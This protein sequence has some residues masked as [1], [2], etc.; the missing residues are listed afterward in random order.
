VTSGA[1]GFD[2]KHRSRALTEGPSRAA[3]RAQ[4]KGIGYDDEALSKPIIGVASTWIETMPC[5]F[6]LRALAAKVKEGI[7]DAGGTPM[8]L[9][10]IAI[11]DGITMGTTGMK[12]SLVS[13]EI[14]ADSIELVARGH[15]F[16]AVIALSGCDKTIPGTVMAL[17]RL[18]V[19]SVML[20]GGSI[21]PGRFKGR[22]VTIQ[23]VFEA[24][25]AHAAGK[26]TDEELHELEG[27]ASPGA[28]ACGG[29]FTAN[30]MA[31]AFEVLGISPMGPSMVPAQYPSKAEVAY[32]AGKL[33][34]DV[35][36]RG[37]KPRDI[38]TR[39]ALEN[40]IAAVT[41]SG[42]STNGVLH[43]LAVAREA[44]VELSIDDFDAISDR[45]PLLCD[46][47]PGGQYVAVDL[48]EA[49]GVPVLVNRLRELGVLHADA[50]TVTGK[51]VGEIADEAEEAPG[52]RVVRGL[53]EPL[54][55]T[56]GLAIL[57]GNLAPEGCVVKLAGHERRL[58]TGPARV[59]DGE[60]AA[61]EAA[62][63]GGISEG[64]VVVIRNEGPVGGP[65]M[66]EM[67]GVTAAINGAGLGDTVALLTDGRFSGATHGFMAGHVAPEAARGGPIAAVQ[68]GDE[69]T[70]DVDGRRI[71][72]ALDDDEIARRV[73][74]YEAP[75]NGDSTGVLAKY[76]ALV[77]SASEGA[78]TLR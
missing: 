43:L 66:R 57:R 69:I 3:A 68:D 75:A 70:I 60:E 71:D 36:R 65:G 7:R 9:N 38:I 6:H 48:H 20:Y 14:I 76:A 18:N 30:T 25:G 63:H 33:V 74:A 53:D 16:D 26:M 17:A 35:L 28:G 2:L 42:G 77:S 73:A 31:M 5:T 78:I 56:G 64:D 27:A 46:L 39:E 41:S 24:V 21:P 72:V 10:T 32:E 47:K 58:H 23:E 49:G 40:A 34:V 54:K 51:T 59:F 15:F 55:P 29:Q 62:T 61:M 11:S 52:Q 37:L 13:R 19:P 12:T 22:D 67:L 1:N 4:L 8:E 44:G 45:T 50:I